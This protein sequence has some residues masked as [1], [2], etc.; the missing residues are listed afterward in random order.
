VIVERA[1]GA[2]IIDIDKKKYLVPGDLTGADG[3][4]ALLFILVVVAL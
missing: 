4:P 1:K 2:D 3:F